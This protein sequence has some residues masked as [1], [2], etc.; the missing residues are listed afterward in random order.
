[1]S[2]MQKCFYWPSMS[3][4]VT[5]HCRSCEKCQRVSKGN[6]RRAP[7]Q[8]REVLTVPFERVCIDI[9][10][11]LPKAS[12]GYNYILTCVDIASR[13]PEAVPLTSITSKAV[14]TQLTDIFAR[15]GF[16]RVLV[17]D[18]GT[19][20]TSKQMYKFCEKNHIQQVHST[21]YR[22]QSNGVVERLHGTLI[23]IAHK[24]IERK[25][26][27]ADML[28]MALYFLRM[29]P[30][31]TSGFSPYMI[32]HGWEPDSPETLLYKGSTGEEHE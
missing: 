28:P 30:S 25:S 15:N 23:P 24:C 6:P 4:D 16:P 2:H 14:I 29:T 1:M 18:N 13:W 7:M 10:G 21:P 19:Q 31:Q 9:V 11:P 17:N 3:R 12:R 32:M 5:K 20:F 22:P 26:E 27:W 8:E